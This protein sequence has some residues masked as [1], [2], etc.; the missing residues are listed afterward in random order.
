MEMDNS[1]D[2]DYMN[3]FNFTINYISESSM[4]ETTEIAQIAN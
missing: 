1:T 4:T 2:Y 3:L